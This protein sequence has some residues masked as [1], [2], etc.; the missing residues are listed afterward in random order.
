MTGRGD[1]RLINLESRRPYV[2]DEDV[3]LIGVR[4]NDEYLE[5]V[6]RLGMGISCSG[7]VQNN[8]PQCIAQA[9]LKTAVQATDG[10]WL[11]LDCD[12]VD[13]SEIP[14][15]DCPEPDGLSFKVLQSVLEP[16][17]ASLNCVGMEVTIYDPD[18]DASGEIAERIVSCLSKAF[19]SSGVT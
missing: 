17:L 19:I 8:D 10:F 6:R 18:L 11:H 14:A 1:A 3:H 9:A 5:E 13:E 15:V 12:V 2:K 16:L 7:K 4:A